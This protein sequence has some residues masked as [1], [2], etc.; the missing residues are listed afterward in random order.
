MWLMHSCQ[1]C[2]QRRRQQQE[3]QRQRQ[4]WNSGP[5]PGAI[6]PGW[7]HLAPSA[8]PARAPCAA[9]RRAAAGHCKFRWWKGWWGLAA[10]L[11]SCGVQGVASQLLSSRLA[12]KT[13]TVSCC[14]LH[15]LTWAA[16]HHAQAYQ[17]NLTALAWA[18]IHHIDVRLVRPAE[19]P[20]R[21]LRRRHISLAF[22]ME[23]RVSPTRLH[24]P[25]HVCTGTGEGV[26]TWGPCE[27]GPCDS[28]PLRRVQE[29]Q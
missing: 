15:P 11:P 7:R 8:P 3:W 16:L 27:A 29:Q 21:L 22:R 25:L 13:F 17:T 26:G 19:G 20:Q 23:G 12:V 24:H 18:V 2:Q 14:P 4:R 10:V 1:S 28:L 6:A 5:S 9:L